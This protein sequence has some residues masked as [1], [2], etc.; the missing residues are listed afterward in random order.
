MTKT[1]Q[2]F[3]PSVRQPD[4]GLAPEAIVGVMRDELRDMP[5][6]GYPYALAPIVVPDRSYRELL[7]ATARLLDLLRRTVLHLAPDR[8]G[9]IAALG[10]EPADC[11]M[12]LDDED[13]ELR[14]CADMAR[15]D[16]VVGADGPKFIEF[17]VS[18]GF[19]G[20]AHF[21]LQQRAWA[22][23]RSLAG[24]PSFVGV[25]VF[26]RLAELVERVSA[27]LGIPPSVVLVGTPRE[28]APA[29]PTRYFD[30]QAELLRQ[31]GIHAVHL[32][33]E[34]LLDGLGRPGPLQYR[35]GI[36]A[37]TVQDAR[38]L[39]YDIGPARAALDAGFVMIPSQTSWLLHTKKVLALLSEAAEVVDGDGGGAASGS[40]RRAGDPHAT[41]GWLRPADR[42]VVARYVPWTRLFG[43]RTVW[44]RGARHQLPRLVL[45]QQE[46]FV[47]KGATGCS[48]DEVTF[49]TRLTPDEWAAAV[50]A[51]LRTDYF[52]VQEVVESAPYSIDVM[53]ESGQVTTCWPARSV[54]SPF[55]LGGRPAGCS[56][57]W[58]VD[59]VPGVVRT[60]S[61]AT[62][63]CLFAEA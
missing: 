1:A 36:A 13:F 55:C 15:A 19:G 35:L 5:A 39:G 59:D 61:G 48:G 33:F 2:W 60:S 49:G 53:D 62:L 57:R 21:A 42:E 3:G 22:R 10:I 30:V 14:H 58:V 52:V 11:P 16:V 7:D 54:V 46:R 18:G 43:D 17:N 6:I 27:E 56:S 12:F 26:A 63:S 45:E 23:I 24:R 34:E 31:H 8:A 4:I 50:E 28:W 51:A 41:M 38:A 37:F 25:D 32:D 44:W 20:L 29:T 47:L 40:G 9:R